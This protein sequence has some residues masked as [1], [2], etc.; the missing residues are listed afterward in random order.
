MS[1]KV[2]AS[3]EKPVTCLRS[4]RQKEGQAYHQELASAP[5]NLSSGSLR[6]PRPP[7]LPYHPL[8]KLR[9]YVPQ[10]TDCAIIGPRPGGPVPG[11]PKTNRNGLLTQDRHSHMMVREGQGVGQGGQISGF[12]A[13][14]SLRTLTTHEKG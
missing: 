9:Q 13:Y 10:G 2:L 5:S 12:L 6:A 3:S 11:Q 7:D 14:L 8:Q 4:S 1:G